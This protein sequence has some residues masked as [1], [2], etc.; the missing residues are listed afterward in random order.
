MLRRLRESSSLSS[1]VN[2]FY[3]NIFIENIEE[4][5]ELEMWSKA[6]V[7]TFWFLVILHSGDQHPGACWE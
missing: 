4:G 1:S 7:R 3:M 5:K 6:R 2:L